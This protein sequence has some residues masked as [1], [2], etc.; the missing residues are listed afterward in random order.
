[1]EVIEYLR[2]SFEFREKSE[3]ELLTLF[4]GSV[5]DKKILLFL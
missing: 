3:K 2:L 1:M 5:K 4:R